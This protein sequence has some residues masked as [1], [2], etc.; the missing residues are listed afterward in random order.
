MTDRPRPGGYLDR[1]ALARARSANTQL[2]E[3]LKGLVD[4]WDKLGSAARL[5]MLAQAGLLLAEQ[6]EALAE[7]ERIR[8]R[9]VNHGSESG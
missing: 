6:G 3:R 5:W 1:A 2:R 8:N 7:M 4:R 9:W